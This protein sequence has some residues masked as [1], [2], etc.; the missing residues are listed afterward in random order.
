MATSDSG[1]RASV[2]KA[3]ARG[4]AW[5]LSI[6]LVNRSISVVSTLILARVLTPSDFGI[7]AL[8][9][10]VYAF[11]DLLGAFGFGS[12]LIQ[13]QD[14]TEAHYNTAWTL[15]LLF[16]LMTSTLLFILAPFAAEFLREPQLE[17]VV[18]FMC[19][20]FLL[21]GVKNIGIINFQKHMAFDKEFRFHLIIKLSGFFV[22]I[23]LALL[24]NSYWAM[25]WGLLSSSVMLILLSYVMQ[26]FR[27]RLALSCWREM[28]SFSAWLQVNNILSYFNRHTENILVSRMLGIAAVGSLQVAR[29]TG[30]LLRELVQPI[31]RAAFPGYARV[32]K[33]PPRMLEVFCDVTAMVMV[34]AFPVALGIIATAH[35]FV[36]TLLGNQWLHIVPLVQWLALASLMMVVMSGTNNVLIALARMKWATAIIASKLIFL[37]CFLIWLLPLYGVLAVGYATVLSLLFVLVLCFVALRITLRLGLGRALHLLYKPA[38]AS[39]IMLV[40]VLFLFP[41]HWGD[42]A[43]VVQFLQLTGAVVAGA[44][45]YGI[46][47]AALWLL[48]SRPEGPELNVLRLVHQRCGFCG[49]LLLK[50][51][52]NA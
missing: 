18:R 16:S 45:C 29:E 37:V 5:T 49:F 7:Y 13:N 32:N 9:M 12:A 31:N 44:F 43:L 39:L 20:L 38:L 48:A 17:R 50:E 10:T 33:D 19:I 34:V 23:P 14:A 35:L 24:L 3:I 40:V 27:P 26:P 52:Q 42:E 51:K 36:P 30:Q 28:I 11:V 1:S 2:G 22:T 25:L 41:R 8:A 21:D 46:A 47:L 15:N 6:R 4:A